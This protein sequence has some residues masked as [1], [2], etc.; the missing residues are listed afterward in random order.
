MAFGESVKKSS[1]NH[2]ILVVC[3]VLM[4][5]C[6]I[7]EGMILAFEGFPYYE[8][9]PPLTRFLGFVWILTGLSCILY[10]R[11]PIFS[12]VGGGTILLVN[13]ISMWQ[14]DPETHFLEWFLYTHSIE[15]LFLVASCTGTFI[16][17]RLQNSRL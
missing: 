13:S 11:W 7:F 5:A 12:V 1:V 17:L 9:L 10:R 16:I 3:W 14:R 4:A 6:L 15:L 2:I 8:H